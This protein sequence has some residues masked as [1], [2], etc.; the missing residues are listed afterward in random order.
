MTSLFSLFSHRTHVARNTQNTSCPSG[1]RQAS[2]LLAGFVLAAA[3]VNLE[4][5][6]TTV[7]C[8][9]FLDLYLLTQ[10]IDKVSQ[11][12]TLIGTGNE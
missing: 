10:K 4:A 2:L 11:V 3:S 6:P 8:V 1:R 5:T 7:P 9:S 12:Q